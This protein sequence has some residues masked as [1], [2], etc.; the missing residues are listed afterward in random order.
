MMFPSWPFKDSKRKPEAT[1]Q[2]AILQII[3][4]RW[5]CFTAHAEINLPVAIYLLVSD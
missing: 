5:T 1:V 4:L 3:F 2:P